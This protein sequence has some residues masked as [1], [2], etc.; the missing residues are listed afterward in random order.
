MSQLAQSDYRKDG[1][2][3]VGRPGAHQL[4]PDS[5]S[6]IGFHLSY[7]DDYGV[8]KSK[9]R[10]SLSILSP[11]YSEGISALR[12]LAFDCDFYGAGEVNAAWLESEA[13]DRITSLFA[14]SFISCISFL[15]VTSV[16]YRSCRTGKSLSGETVSNENGP[17][18]GPITYFGNPAVIDVLKDEPDMQ[19]YGNRLLLRL[20]DDIA[21]PNALKSSRASTPF[22]ANYRTRESSRLSRALIAP[23]GGAT[24]PASCKV[25]RSAGSAGRKIEAIR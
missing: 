9:E 22:V 13:I 24:A 20:T 2:R 10:C 17:I 12:G 15:I 19:P 1:F 14:Q 6:N 11:A 21:M 5:Y 25:S 7:I 18:I 16:I 4:L 23:I 8:K 3:N